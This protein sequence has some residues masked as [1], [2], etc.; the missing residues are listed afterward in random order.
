MKRFLGLFC[1]LILVIG[2]SGFL[3]AFSFTR[4]YSFSLLGEQFSNLSRRDLLPLL[5]IME[6]KW[7]KKPFTLQIGEQALLI[8]KRKLGITWNHTTIR[9]AILSGQR[10]VSLALSFNEEQIQKFLQEIVQKFALLPQ[11]A[12]FKNQRFIRSQEGSILNVEKSLIELKEKLEKGM[13]EV[14]LTHFDP[15][16]PQHDTVSLL[17][18]KGFPY[19]LARYETSLQDRDEDV[20]FN[21]KKAAQ[22]IDGIIVKKG[23]VFSFN[24]VV[25]KADQEDGYRKT[26]IVVN[27]KLVPGYGGGVCQVS[28]TL[29]NALL[30]TEAEI[31]ERHPHSGYSPTT[32]YVPP[33][34]DAAV[35]YGAKDLRFNFPNQTVVIFA[36]TISDQL[37]CEIWG[38]KENTSQT[39][40]QVHIVSLDKTKD[41][42]GLLTVKTTVT[43]N[44]KTVY[45]FQNTYLTPW[46]FG[47]SLDETQ[48]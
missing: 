9:N 14:E 18:A 20:I 40:I 21:I 41:N 33:G 28:T 5:E 19:L 31:L 37:I 29:Y 38:E 22:A 24:Q 43:R 44:G 36:Y 27:G 15:I 42:D 17:T 13:D 23:T 30:H 48:F 25:G 35:S 39:E 46:D 8:D 32:S 3:F 7:Q 47:K 16:P 6:K 34:R 1:A 45:R 2:G 4:T 26:Q 12:S 10:E 11:N